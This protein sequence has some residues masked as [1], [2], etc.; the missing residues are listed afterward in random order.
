MSHL[1]FW[2]LINMVVLLFAIWKMMTSYMGIHIILGAIGF[3]FVLY[4]WTRHAV[5]STI[6]S[7]ISRKRKIKYAKLTKRVRKYH[8]WVGIFALLFI[9]FH[10][11]L[12]LYYYNFHLN[13]VKILSGLGAVTMLTGLVITG[14]RRKW[15]KI[16]HRHIIHLSFGYATFTFVLIHLIL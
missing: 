16:R 1:S 10:G 2:F 9:C 3:L 14:F 6:R 8:Q 13:N 15:R 7:N 4:N 5:Y 11:L 12:V